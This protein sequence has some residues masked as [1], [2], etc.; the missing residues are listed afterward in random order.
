MS[1]WLV[2]A[3]GAPTNTLALRKRLERITGWES[4]KR[5][6]ATP[7]PA[8]CP[9]GGGAGSNVISETDRPSNFDFLL[10]TYRRLKPGLEENANSPNSSL[11]GA[12]YTVS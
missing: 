7:S 2:L 4:P 10:E 3:L 9:R 12:V 5:A 8:A 1:G 6:P 11:G